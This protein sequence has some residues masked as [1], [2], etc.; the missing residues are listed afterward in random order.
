M[1]V[2]LAVVV[3]A[4]L[5]AAGG[6]VAWSLR[7]PATVAHIVAATGGT[8]ATDDGVSIR[9]PAGALSADTDV[10][11]APRPSIDAP[12]GLTWLAE[13]VGVSLGDATLKA[14]ATVTLPLRE[15]E[16]G[17]LIAVVSRD[18][19]RVWS[20]EGGMVD[21]AARTITTTTANLAILSAG[22]A[23]VS[24]PDLIAGAGANDAPAADCGTLRSQ[25]WSVRV[26]GAS[27]RTCV[28]AG[29]ADRP[30]LMRVVSDRT[31]GLFAELGRY[32]PITVSQPNRSS[33]ADTVWRKLAEADRNR[34][35]LPGQ[36][37]L[38]VSLP[39]NLT[40]VDFRTR[41]GP[42][43]S[44]AEY[45]VAVMSSAFVPADVT[46]Q[47]VRC[48]LALPPGQPVPPCVS[49]AFAATEPAMGTQGWADRADV[50]G[51]VLAALPGLPGVVAAVPA[52]PGGWRVF[53]QRSPVIPVK[54]LNEPGGAIPAVVVATQQRLYAAAT[55]DALP[56]LV[57][58]SGLIYANTPLTG[59]RVTSAVAALVTTPPLRWPCDE[60]SRDGYV[61][62]MA[63][64]DLLTYPARLTDLGLTPEDVGVVRQTA[65]Q[66]KNYRLCIALDGTWT[67]LTANRPPGEFPAGDAAD[68]ATRGCR[69]GAF[70]PP[71][72]FCRSLTRAD[73]DGDGRTD[74]LL[75]LRRGEQW[76]ARAI[77]A[78]GRVSDL[79]LPVDDPMVVES[80][81]LDGEPGEE[82]VVQSGSTVRLLSSTSA[83]LVRIAVDFETATSLERTAGI[84]CSDVDG[85]GRPE[86]I[87]GSAAFDRDPAT[88]AIVAATTLE[89][90]WT[91]S[92]KTLQRGDSIQRHLTGAQAIAAAA[93]PYRD[94]TC[95]WR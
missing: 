68:V 11:I 5:L 34:T 8:I 58:P 75:L 51:S 90:R 65:A 82:I 39:G 54:A 89:T 36:G 67:V 38:D 41:T 50:R 21:R 14:P 29:A 83:G 71:D 3:A 48:A 15:D 55:R 6:V 25:R 42:D 43:V 61:Y 74:S 77:L 4:V 47:A 76:T 28:A 35:Y 84:G 12:D 79:A 37:T 88:G 18:V 64:P 93:P 30:A 16:R 46:V 95:V 20:T 27:V 60:T 62:G 9:F 31:S 10:R 69:A 86:L 24:A 32:P 23:V 73:L 7:S 33:L 63:D 91:W 53:A 40:T 56:D 17:G 72:A 52:E 22:R 59:P 2:A 13:P 45:L 94:V 44:T 66:G 92:G 57:P 26:E 70:V 78:A 49:E 19:N 81:D 87:A 85:D 80:L 1:R